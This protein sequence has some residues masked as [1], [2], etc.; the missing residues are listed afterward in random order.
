MYMKAISLGLILGASAWLF[1]AEIEKHNFKPPNGY[2]PN[3]PTAVK[4][5]TAVWEPIYGEEKIANEKPYIAV[6]TNGVWI[7]EGTL[8]KD[9][10]GGVAVAEI[11][12]DDGRILRI[13][14]GK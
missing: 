1:A 11:S 6:L 7:V 5:A 4:I 8:L 12:K 9:R 13:S 3:A 14:H 2:V 10:K